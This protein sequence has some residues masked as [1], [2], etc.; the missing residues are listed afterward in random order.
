[1]SAELQVRGAAPAMPTRRRS[2]AALLATSAALLSGCSSSLERFQQFALFLLDASGANSAAEAPAATI[3]TGQV[4]VGL[5]L[6][7][8]AGGN[9]GLAG[10]AMRNAAEMALAE[11]NSPNIQLLVQDDAGNADA[12]RSVA[13]QALDQGAQIIL[14]PLFA[15]SVSVV[16][17]I[18]QPRNI[19]VIAFSTD[20]NVAVSGR[21]SVELFAGVRRRAHRAICKFDRKA[22]VRRAGAEQSIRHGG[23]S[24]IQAGCCAAQRP[25]RRARTLSARQCRYGRA[26]ARRGAGSGACRCTV[27]PRWR[28]C[29]PRRDPDVLLP[30]A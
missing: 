15:Q 5:I 10:E 18:T 9:A 25:D 21:I 23:R 16:G 12:A 24:G 29:C 27:P 22:V 14:G 30:T 13:Q 26:R 6:P 8:S 19:P 1:M 17:Q 4:K 11:F 28:R 20:A 7:V 3:G 2:V